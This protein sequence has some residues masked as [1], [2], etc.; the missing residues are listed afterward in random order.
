MGTILSCVCVLGEDVSLVNEN[1]KNAISGLLK[2]WLRELPDTIIPPDAL[3]ILED[4]CGNFKF[5]FVLFFFYFLF[6]SVVN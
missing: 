1:D 4:I 5:F 6:V 3:T 2:L